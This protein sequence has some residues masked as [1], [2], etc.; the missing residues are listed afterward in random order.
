M[1]AWIQDDDFVPEVFSAGWK[2]DPHRT[3][4]WL[5][6]ARPVHRIGMHD[7]REVWLVTRYGDARAALS[8]RRLVKH[9]ERHAGVAPPAH[10]IPKRVRRLLLR[11]MLELDPPDHT[12]LRGLVAD[13]FAP[14]RMDAL[15]PRVQHITD[16]LLDE[17]AP[18]GGGDLIASLAYP[19][20]ITVI[21]EML[22]VPAED[23]DDFR[24]WSGAIIAGLGGAAADVVEPA[25][26]MADYL[27]ALV[28][29]KRS[30]SADDLLSTL[31]AARDGA[32]RL[33]DD[34]VVSMAFLLLVAGHETVAG[35]IGTSLLALLTAPDQ[36][37]L[38]TGEGRPT[39]A[40][41]DEL[42]RFSSPLEFTTWRV[43]AEAIALGGVDIPRG[44][45][46][47]VVLGSANRDALRFA[48]PEQVDLTRSSNRHLAFGHGIHYCL[49]AHLARVEGAI[50]VGST[51]RRLPN[52]RL[53][54]DPGSLRWRPGFL[55]RA[56]DELPVSWDV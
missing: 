30:T 15:A 37:A 8:D 3:Y 12:R 2:A 34:E 13:A 19:L 45:N 17:L 48:S 50:A 40:D 35:L 39:A 47:L 44:A 32:D 4:A 6:S 43:A 16:T 28:S 56:L 33:S 24:A 14:R 20:P 29:A 38:V 31:V 46:V 51:L 7:G 21:C 1:T 42:L 22:G 55:V 5:R 11:N 41:V 27:L 52:L 53:A 10:L 36:R 26:R 54:G 23:Q 49:G 9:V 25:T 18:R